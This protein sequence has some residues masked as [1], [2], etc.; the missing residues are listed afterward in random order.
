MKQ[1]AL[2]ASFWFLPETPNDTNAEFRIERADL[3]LRFTEALRRAGV[4]NGELDEWKEAAA[5]VFSAA[6]KPDSIWVNRRAAWEQFNAEV[7]EHADYVL[8]DFPGRFVNLTAFFGVAKLDKS[9]SNEARNWVSQRWGTGQGADSRHAVAAASAI[10]DTF[11]GIDDGVVDISAWRSAAAT[12]LQ[13]PEP[14][15]PSRLIRG[16]GRRPGFVKRFEEFWP[17]DS[18]DAQSV[19]RA[20]RDLN[21]S[22]E[23]WESDEKGPREYSQEIAR[24]IA[25]ASGIPATTDKIDR[26]EWLTYAAGDFSSY[27]SRARARVFE[28]VD[29]RKEL[30][31]DV[32]PADA[33]AFNEIEQFLASSGNALGVDRQYL[34]RRAIRGIDEVLKKWEITDSAGV[35][36][37]K[38]A[39][40]QV[41]NP[42]FG[43][44]VF[45]EWL[46][47]HPGVWAPDRK[48]TARLIDEFV[49]TQSLQRKL[50]TTRLPTFTHADP[51]L[52]PHWSQFGTSRMRK[53]KGSNTVFELDLWD[54]VSVRG[55]RCRLASARYEAEL[56][57]T[58]GATKA[59]RNDR[60]GR[61]AAGVAATD[62]VDV[63]ARKLDT[64]FL[65]F[66][67]SQV[68]DAGPA[69]WF[70]SFAVKLEP[71][72]PGLRWLQQPGLN[73]NNILEGK[74]PAELRVLGVDLGM[75]VEFGWAVWELVDEAY[76]SNIGG[77]ATNEREY[78]RADSNERRAFGE[79]SFHFRRIA[80]ASD[81]SPATWALLCETGT[82]SY[83]TPQKFRTATWIEHA[84]A[85]KALKPFGHK[86]PVCNGA[87]SVH[88]HPEELV[89]HLDEAARKI[90]HEQR[91]IARL[92]KALV[93][94]E[95]EDDIV[96]SLR[97]FWAVAARQRGTFLADWWEKKVAGL[98]G[99]AM[100][101]ERQKWWS[102]RGEPALENP[103]NDQLE[104]AAQA[105]SESSNLGRQLEQEWTARDAEFRKL[106]RALRRLVFG[107]TL[108]EAFLQSLGL[109]RRNI[110]DGFKLLGVQV[111][112]SPDR[113]ELLDRLTR[114][115]TS[116]W[117]R[118]RPSGGTMT[119]PEQLGQR[120]IEK[121]SNIRDDISKQVASAIVKTA[122]E[123]NCHVV[124]IEDLDKYR[125]SDRRDPTQNRTL[126]IWSKQR[127]REHVEE[128]C[129]L[130]GL[131]LK[132]VNPAWT[133]WH[134]CRNDKPGF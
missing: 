79:Y 20:L 45:Y 63:A 58:P 88:A 16:R 36:R 133:S 44:M 87:G 48:P 69:E 43:D 123:R 95:T 7:Q 22:L 27:A 9:G 72:G 24:R 134:D 42:A 14:E 107:G 56:S 23:K 4:Q 39:H 50:E 18:F 108:S 113:F 11:P 106:L 117:T 21:Q 111:G 38:A 13:C 75:R 66:D 115:Q 119:R 61:I 49:K 12:R 129:S 101:E 26:Y 41:E 120:L 73:E 1:R 96:A 32:G 6:I 86:I 5:I 97:V 102:R 51:A 2:L 90:L 65:R 114:L 81:A 60:L 59:S 35:L 29:W 46:A 33:V 3:P 64:M 55:V 19:E 80:D 121:R 110:R 89:K 62:V 116:Y 37:E 94:P 104:R 99:V 78:Q 28:L 130:H 98:L 25:V 118:L 77:S 53:V 34:R 52:H 74:S 31:N 109:E 17:K 40:A 71:A 57:S 47:E 8:R 85:G 10:L 125:Q 70:A 126:R 83:T 124:V 100:T 92:S 84:I 131:V 105:L 68:S 67:R 122:L 91:C 112:R 132:A 93:S 127:V 76:L 128:L 103:S 54:G 30:N 82:Q 15:I